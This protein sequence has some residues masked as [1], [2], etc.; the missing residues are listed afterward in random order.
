LLEQERQKN[1]ERALR[2]Q[3]ARES[4]ENAAMDRQEHFA[5]Y[6]K[7]DIA[8]AASF[9]QKKL[10]VHKSIRNL[11]GAIGSN[12]LKELPKAK[13]VYLKQK[14][15]RKTLI[16]AA[17]LAIISCSAISII[18]LLQLDAVLSQSLYSY[19]LRI[20]PDL[21]TLY[22]TTVRVALAVLFL[23]L[24]VS[25]SFQLHSFTHKQWESNETA[26]KSSIFRLSDGSTIAIKTILKNVRKIN[27]PNL[28][29]PVYSIEVETIVELAELP[30]NL[31]KQ[32][33]ENINPQAPFIQSLRKKSYGSFSED[34]SY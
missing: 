33:P 11:L 2:Q 28:E 27:H 20:N 26:S 13:A 15:S 6:E 8:E 14:P 21:A 5:P 29:K 32:N 16:L 25:A 12:P 24:I 9:G 10:T 18:A 17:N 34:Q 19:G 3:R 4:R 30:E 1:R 31:A 7:Q 23:I 22:L